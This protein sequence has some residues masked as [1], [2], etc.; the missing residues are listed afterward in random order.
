MGSIFD[1]KTTN[2]NIT[3]NENNTLDTVVGS[4]SDIERELKLTRKGNEA[5]I[6]GEDLEDTEEIDMEEIP[7]EAIENG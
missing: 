7:L 3:S 5:F 4:L 6:Y 2:V 1:K